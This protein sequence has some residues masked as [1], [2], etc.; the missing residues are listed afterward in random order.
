MMKRVNGDIFTWSHWRHNIHHIN[1]TIPMIYELEPRRGLQTQKYK[2]N[3]RMHI[4]QDK[5]KY[6]NEKEIIQMYTYYFIYY[7][8]RQLNRHIDVI[9]PLCQRRL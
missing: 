8:L 5:I 1:W 9:F 4:I 6:R 3:G 2:N 7:I